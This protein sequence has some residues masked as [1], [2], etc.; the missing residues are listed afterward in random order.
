MSSSRRVTVKVDGHP[1]PKGSKK[2]FLNPKTKRVVMVDQRGK[3]LKEW[4]GLLVEAFESYEGEL[5]DGP[6]SVSL[7]FFLPRPKKSKFGAYPAGSPDIDKLTRTVFDK[8]TGVFFT[9]DSRVVEL[10][11]T[12]EWTDGTPGVVIQV[13]EV[14]W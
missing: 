12:K 4:E 13:G 2:A 3:L 7:A 5:L 14:T 9:D 10:D 11:A 1:R 6:V 8:M